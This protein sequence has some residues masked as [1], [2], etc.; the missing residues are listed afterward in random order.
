LDEDPSGLATSHLRDA[1]VSLPQGM[2][3]NPGAVDGVRA[4]EA[5]GPEGINIEGPLSEDVGPDGEL[6]LAPGDCPDASIL[7]T[8]EAITPL[9]PT[10]VKGHVFLAR[11][12]CGGPRPACTEQDAL[13]GN[14]YKL[15]LELGGTGELAATGVHIKLEGRTEVNPAT[16]QLTGRF[17]G[18]P[19]TPFSE[20]KVHL[21][22]G[23]RAPLANPATCGR[24][25]TSGDF[26]PW[27][28]AG[29][30]PEGAL[31]DGIGDATPSSFFEVTGCSDPQAFDP[32]LLAGT[33]STTA[34][35][36]TPF[37]MEVSRSDREQ[38]IKGLRL[39]TPPGLLAMLSSVPLCGEA[40]ADA[41][42]CPA[43]AKIGTTRVASG[44]GS[45]PFEIE[46]DV[47][48]TGPY[49]GAPFGL[50]VVTHAV[51]G[52]FDLGLIV[53]RAAIEIDRHDS[54]ATIAVDETGPHAIPAVLFGVPLRLQRITARIDRPGFM[55]NPTSCASGHAVAATVSGSAGA[56]AG[57]VSPLATTGCRSLGF[58]PLFSVFTNAHTSR[59]RGASLDTRLAYPKG[60][61][62]ADAN[63]ASVKVDLP[64]QLP[65]RL[66]TLQKA[67]PASV[68]DAD[69]AA[70]P[71]AS[72]VGVVRARTPVLPV[73]LS[74]P[75][76]FVSHGGEAFPSL[77]VVL[78]GDGVR[79]DL[80]GTTF[81]K[82]GVTSST[83]KTVPDVPVDTFEL[84]LPQG[85]FSA[86]AASEN[87]CRLRGK[88]KMPTEFVA[89]NG[90]VLRQRTNIAVVGC[91]KAKRGRRRG[92]RAVRAAAN[93]RT[94]R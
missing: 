39:H 40:Q 83:F 82:K 43:S 75:V 28:A 16:G 50:S 5:E 45:H 78:Q 33:A 8:A 38:F 74:G 18:N 66:S 59:A 77:V 14:L 26:V 60:S 49:R 86:L 48:L 2:S 41:G 56:V 71:P 79:V 34:G 93:E 85:R 92:A 51:A 9:L 68:F 24:A 90:S 58:K 19:Q 25:V 17:T 63:I 32:G 84:Y 47:Y 27:A 76:Y 61:F 23:P 67:C 6:Q 94:G 13:D 65:S 29:R 35:A 91:A 12:G 42:T 11:P 22:G 81:I 88:L 64:R 46:G 54:T 62:G 55:F 21:N 37:T 15:Y 20:L 89:Q 52:P 31:V 1:A 7:G 72:V 10:P 57:P 80:T 53:V 70:C 44:A 36:F 73:G 4:C 3:V 69:P 30:T 87:L